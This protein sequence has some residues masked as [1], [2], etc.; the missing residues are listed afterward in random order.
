M[1][2]VK[3]TASLSL[4]LDNQWSYMRTH[5]DAGWESYPSYLAEVLPLSL[6]TLAAQGLKATVFLVGRD[7]E[8]HREL[9]RQIP[10]QGHE[11]GN[12]SQNH[13][14]WLHQLPRPEL[15]REIAQ[16][17]EFIAIATGIRPRGFRGPGFACSETLLQILAERGYE[18][19]CSTFPTFIGPLARSYYFMTARKLTAQEKEER[20]DLFGD[21]RDGF[22][23]LRSYLW[24]FDRGK[25]QAPLPELLEIPVTTMP[26]ARTPIHMSYVLYLA[27]RSTFLA[28]RYLQTALRLC[29]LFKIEPSFLLHPLD[30]ISGDTCAA[31]R[32]FPAMAMPAAEKRALVGQA[33]SMLADRFDV[34]PMGEHARRLRAS[35]SLP[36]KKPNLAA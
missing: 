5:G 36:R 30:F 1:A 34:V 26:G 22:R 13:L 2:K 32:F 8:S 3:P 18:Y 6:Q 11:V 15:E 35:G 17:E 9:L 19:D 24:T 27:Q 14:Q 16:A 29:E 21:V 10:A 7:A 31:L 4:D 28:L 33:L 12:H 20:Q 25:T 23:P